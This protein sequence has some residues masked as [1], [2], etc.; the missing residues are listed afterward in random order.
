MGYQLE[1][2]TQ[3]TLHG[4]ASSDTTVTIAS[5]NPAQLLLSKDGVSA[6]QASI[7]LV[8]KAGFNRTPPF[9]VYALVNNG[10]ATYTAT[11]PGFGAANGTVN[12]APS[13]FVLSGPFGLGADFS[14]T[15][16]SPQSANGLEVQSYRLDSS[17]NINALEAV[18]GGLSVNLNITSSQP[19]IGTIS[20]SPA[21]FSAGV[22]D[23][24]AF[25][26]EPLTDGT[27]LLSASASGFTTP[28]AGVF[29]ESPCDPA[30]R[31]SHLH[32]RWFQPTTGVAVLPWRAG[33]SGGSQSR[34]RRADRCCY[35]LPEPMPGALPS[36]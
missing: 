28:A 2:T 12:F 26:L 16:G 23:V 33:S 29:A 36:R 21:V 24:I 18:A 25:F 4:A 1:D 31:H 20:G 32:Q 8:I 7:S 9:Y 13:G 35:R 14:T 5:N 15:T 30:A 6:G 27:T 34:S 11:V 3:V 19:A 22:S 17:G 10:S